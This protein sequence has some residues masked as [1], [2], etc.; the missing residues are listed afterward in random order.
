MQQQGLKI[1]AT[2]LKEVLLWAK[3]YQVALYLQRNLPWKGES[4][5]ATTFIV[6]LRNWDTATLLLGNH[7]P[8]QP[9]IVNI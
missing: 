7:H 9:P 6:V 3:C 1:L 4:T 8:D 2:I 5:N